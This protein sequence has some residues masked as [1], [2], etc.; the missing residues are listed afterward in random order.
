VTPF[1]KKPALPAPILVALSA[2]IPPIHTLFVAL[3]ERKARDFLQRAAQRLAHL[4]AAQGGIVVRTDNSGLLA[5]FEQAEQAL[6]CARALRRD[7][8]HWVQPITQEVD[9][10]VDIGISYGRVLGQPP[11]YEGQTLVHANALAAAAQGGQILLETAVVRQLPPR[12]R[13]TLQRVQRVE[14]DSDL[15]EAWMDPPDREDAQTA[16]LW[17]HLQRPQGGLEQIVIPGSVIH[18]GRSSRAEVTV[19]REDVSRLHAVVLWRDGDYTLTDL[20]RNGTWLQY[21]Q[22]GVVVRVRRSAVVLRAA[23]ALYFGRAPHAGQPPDLRF[24]VDRPGRV[25]TPA[26]TGARPRCLAAAGGGSA[27]PLLVRSEG[28]RP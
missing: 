16:P 3:G 2:E 17:L 9:V 5:L 14:W 26:D 28:T 12:L 13:E 8:A 11:D 22:S 20:S 7:L 21:G 1:W 6:T 19:E 27:S 15:T 23:G 24:L 25:A 10:H 18:I 4:A